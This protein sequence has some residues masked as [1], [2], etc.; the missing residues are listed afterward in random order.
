MS[1]SQNKT[2]RRWKDGVLEEKAAQ[3]FEAQRGDKCLHS[4][5]F[6]T[7]SFGSASRLGT[8]VSSWTVMFFYCLFLPVI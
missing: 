6:H 2:E 8:A 1:P 3:S 4:S 7:L 5:S